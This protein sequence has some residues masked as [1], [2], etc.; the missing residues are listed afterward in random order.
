MGVPAVTWPQSRV[1]N[2][3]RSGWIAT[4]CGLAMTEVGAYSGTT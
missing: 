1:V 2:L 3:G 4:A